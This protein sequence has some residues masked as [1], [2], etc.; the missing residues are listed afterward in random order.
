MEVEDSKIVRGREEGEVGD[1]RDE[2]SGERDIQS[3]LLMGESESSVSGLLVGSH[4][5]EERRWWE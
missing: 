5:E 1:S 4:L 3:S 2:S